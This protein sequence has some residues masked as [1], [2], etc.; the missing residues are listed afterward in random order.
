MIEPRVSQTLG[1]CVTFSL[2]PAFDWALD[3]AR[4][5]R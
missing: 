1:P 4:G 3:T 2:E 5:L